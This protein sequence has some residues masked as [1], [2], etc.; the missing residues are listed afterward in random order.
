[1]G[2][3][4]IFSQ[5]DYKWLIG[6]GYKCV[7]MHYHTVYSDG[8]AT[9]DQVLEKIRK[10]G[11]GVAITD[12]CEI[13]GSLEIF[14]K[15]KKEDFIIPGIEVTSDE[16]VDVLFYFYGKEEM[17]DFF[18]KEILPL[19]IKMIHA[20][21]IKL[22]LDEVMALE[23]KYN[24]ITSLPHPFGYALR[25][26][27]KDLFEKH[28]EIL[29]HN[30]VFEAINGGNSRKQ[31]L[32]SVEYIEKYKKGITGGTDGHSIYPLGNIIT[33]SK[34]DTVKEFLENITQKNNIVIGTETKHG[35]VG[36]FGKIAV[37]KIRN[38][39]SK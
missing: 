30:K 22:P 28:E 15:K 2:K 11:I 26:G 32:R 39:F 25:T 21:K 14:E 12:H 13:K 29:K 31:N 17:I 23:R 24:C 18:N 10:L 20:T 5:P 7:D 33:C 3:K 8:A 4:I 34:A 35:K 19:R 27:V 9:I 16:N 6:Q 1:M 38:F 37:N 36:E